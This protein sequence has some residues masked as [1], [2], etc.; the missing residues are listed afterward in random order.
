MT[1]PSGPS[2]LDAAAAATVREASHDA[3][4]EWLETDGLGGF[5]SGTVSLLRTRR[6]HA[7]LLA[8]ANPPTD[9]YVLVNGFDAWVETPEGSHPLTA[10]RYAPGVTHPPRTASLEGFHAEPFPRWVYGLPGPIRLEQEIFVRHG[11]PVTCLRWHLTHGREAVLCVRLYLSGRD[12]HALHKMNGSFAFEPEQG[13]GRCLWHPYPGVPS[14]AAITNG[15]YEH[16]PDWYRDF[17]YEEEQARG[18]D[19]VEDLAAPG[20][21]R[22]DLVKDDALLILSAQGLKASPAGSPRSATP[23]YAEH[24]FFELKRRTAL[25][26]RLHRS[27]DAYLVQRGGGRT[28]IAG[29][30]WFTDWGRDTFLSLRGLCLAAGRLR[31]ARDILLEWAGTLSDGMIPNRF[32]DR[33]S[34]PEYNSVDAS[35][36]YVVALEAFLQASKSMR[37]PLS[38][39]DHHH[40]KETVEKILDSYCRGTRFGIR[41]D[42]DGLLRCGEPGTQLTWMDARISGRAVTPRVG[43]PVEVQALWLNALSAG[44]R[45]SKR[46]QEIFVKGSVSF[47]PRFW[48]EAKTCLYDVVDVDHRPGVVDDAFRANQIFAVGGLPQPLLHGDK[49]MKLVAAVE[50][51]LLTPV[52]LRTLAPD[53]PGYVSRYEGGVEARDGAYHQGLVWPYLLGPFV[54]AWIRVHGDGNGKPSALI[55]E[56]KT[57]FLQPLLQRMDA[58]GIGHLPELADAEPPFASRGCPFQAWSLAEPLRLVEQVLVADSTK[59]PIKKR[60]RSPASYRPL[61]DPLTDS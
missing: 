52:G 25:P 14:I 36:W 54:E 34:A 11:S 13:R 2:G 6:Y 42:D 30:P 23:L 47:E 40:L 1:S 3:G 51:K 55:E 21:F 7:L 43:K 56:A 53:E 35:L 31:E 32:P 37:P 12:L 48:N 9:R 18:L 16:R 44:I 46:W 50:K 29:Y 27:A 41:V 10:Q 49:A 59:T 24:R 60:H 28:V 61:S 58:T 57:R 4:A 26:S 5:A 17:L 19:S 45:L 22:F 33:G 20:I 39:G 38:V 15:K 8:S